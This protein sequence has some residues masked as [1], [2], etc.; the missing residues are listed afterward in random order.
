MWNSFILIY[1]AP[2]HSFS[3]WHHIQFFQLLKFMFNIH[4]VRDTN[5]DCA[6][7]WIFQ[8][9]TGPYTKQQINIRMLPYPKSTICALWPHALHS[10]HHYPDFYHHSGVFHGFERYIN[11]FTLNVLFCVWFLLSNIMFVRFISIISHYWRLLI[12]WISSQRWLIL[13]FHKYK[14]FLLFTVFIF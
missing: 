10:G 2:V 13:L 3:L 11:G 14:Q 5:H 12:L 8:N 6:F 4:S 7:Q 9:W 1:A